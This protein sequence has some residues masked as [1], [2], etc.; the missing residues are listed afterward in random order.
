MISFLFHW[1]YFLCIIE[2]QSIYLTL[3]TLIFAHFIAQ[4]SS[5]IGLIKRKE[6]FIANKRT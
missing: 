3:S 6:T 4:N 1:Q 2:N 5:I